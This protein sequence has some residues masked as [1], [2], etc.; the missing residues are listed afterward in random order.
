MN[1]YPLQYREVIATLNYVEHKKTATLLH[2]SAGILK[3]H[4]WQWDYLNSR[5]GLFMREEVRLFWWVDQYD[6]VHVVKQSRN[7][8]GWQ[9]PKPR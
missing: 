1:I 8:N 4:K 7:S 5:I 2:T 9:L 6:Y 3:I